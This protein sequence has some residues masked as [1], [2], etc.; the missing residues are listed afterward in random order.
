MTLERL[1]IGRLLKTAGLG[2]G[3]GVINGAARLKGRGASVSAIAGSGDG[4]INFA[5]GSGGSV[6]ALLLDLSGLELGKALL[7]ALDIPDREGI[8]CMGVDFVLR[9]G[10]MCS[11]VLALET[12][13][14]VITGGGAVDLGREVMEHRHRR[15]AILDRHAGDADPHRRAVQGSALRA[16]CR[17]GDRGG[18]AV[19]LGVL[20]PPAALLPTIHFGVG[21]GSPCSGVKR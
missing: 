5:M 15:Q 9:K 8:R 20:F 6:D 11:R 14:H 13:G 16:R 17:A 1:D 18:A 19:G 10:T 12:T 2:D 4:G 3:A 21:E 7:A